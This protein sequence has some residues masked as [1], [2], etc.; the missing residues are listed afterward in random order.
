M[1]GKNSDRDPLTLPEFKAKISDDL[2][3]VMSSW[4]DSIH[5]CQWR[6]VSCGRRHQRVT[7]LD[8]Q[9]Q[10]FIGTISPNVGNLSFFVEAKPRKQ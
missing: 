1:V 5:F 2:L 7:L 3:G 6:G 10:K 9:L 4:K 8:L